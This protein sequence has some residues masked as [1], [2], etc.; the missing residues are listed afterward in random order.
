VP[1]A[2]PVCGAVAAMVSVNDLADRPA[3]VLSEDRELAL[4]DKHVRWLDTPSLPHNWEC[5]H[6]FEV[7]T[8][9]LFCGDVLTHMGGAELAALTES[10]VIGA[11]E[12]TRRAMPE[13]SVVI[14]NN[15]RRFL[16]K[17]ASTVP[18]TLAL[19][20]GSSYRGQ[21]ARVLRDLAVALGT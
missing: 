12:A 11:G 14:D 3:L 18:A 15:T 19:M 13:G 9:T 2:Q 6:L 10:D 17:L 7:T 8:R 21:G 5:G 1:Q 16:E 4:G 20:H